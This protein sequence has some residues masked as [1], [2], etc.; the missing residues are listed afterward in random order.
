[1]AIN[2]AIIDQNETYRKSLKT[3][4]EQIEGFRVVFDSGDFNCGSN[5]YNNLLEV[6]LIDSSIG[7][8]KCGELIVEALSQRNSIKVL[9]LA[10]YREELTLD[11][12]NV[13]IILKS[14]GKKEFESRIRELVKC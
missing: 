5:F 10:V 11:Y 14:S 4:L 13:A 6:M 7:K 1:M 9:M 3:L 2:I 12:G 8:Q